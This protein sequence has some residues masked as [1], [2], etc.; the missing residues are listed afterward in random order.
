MIPAPRRPGGKEARRHLVIAAPRRPGGKE[1]RRHLVIAAP[2]RQ[3]GKEARRHLVIAAPRMAAQSHLGR[4]EEPGSSL[5][6][7][8]E[9]LS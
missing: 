1:A 8:G 5:S 3:G 6:Q 9:I 7:G 2:R 4:V